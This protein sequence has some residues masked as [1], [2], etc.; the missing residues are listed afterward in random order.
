MFGRFSVF[1]KGRVVGV[2][3]LQGGGLGLFVFCGKNCK[4]AN[5]SVEFALKLAVLV[6]CM[7]LFLASWL[8][9]ALGLEKLLRFGC[10]RYAKIQ[11]VVP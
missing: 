9:R 7:F 2:R 5:F 10:G 3:C 11:V 4:K 8:R 1:G 6:A